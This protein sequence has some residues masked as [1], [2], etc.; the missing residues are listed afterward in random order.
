T[1]M[2]RAMPSSVSLWA[3]AFTDSLEDDIK[4]IHCALDILDQSPLGS[5]AG[6]GTPIALDRALSA[7]VL[8]FKKV[9]ANPIYCANSRGK[10]EALAL[11]ALSQLALT[12]NKFASDVML[13][14]TH[15]FG[16][17]TVHESLC[18]GS[19][20]MPQKKNPDAIEL[21]R[22]KTNV[23]NS[24]LF[25]ALS[26][27]QNLPS[28]YNRDLQLTKAPLISGIETMH[29][30]LSVAET[31][32]STLKVNKSALEKAMSPGLFAAE[33]AHALTSKGMAFRDAYRRVKAEA[34]I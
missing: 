22:G 7:K 13:F 15:E 1:H 3:D 8:G 18:T 12:L 20:M 9:Q 30:C 27:M 28:G 33:K 29:E 31:A 6:Y 17:F 2:Q 23:V 24:Q 34:N 4:L 10:F 26:V 25:Q 21:L 32:I 5:G 19:S 14:S 11:S 16:F